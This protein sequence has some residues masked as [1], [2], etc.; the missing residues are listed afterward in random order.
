MVISDDLL[1]AGRSAHS[2]AALFPSLCHIFTHKDN[3][4]QAEAKA[5]ELR[6]ARARELELER[7]RLQEAQRRQE[8]EAESLR[9]SQQSHAMRG[10]ARG[11]GTTAGPAV[12]GRSRI[13]RVKR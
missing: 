2:H 5:E 1:S 4:R 12:R 11:R 8:E 6:L 9:Q 13:G 7:Q 3:R 10:G